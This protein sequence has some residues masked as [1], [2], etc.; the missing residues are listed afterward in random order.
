M[1]VKLVHI[2]LVYLNDVWMVHV[3]HDVVLELHQ[4]DVVLNSFSEDTLDSYF[5]QWVGVVL[6]GPNLPKLAF[7]YYLS[8]FVNFFDVFP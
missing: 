7:S 6:S 4:V 2:G 8:K 3:F 5:L 1:E